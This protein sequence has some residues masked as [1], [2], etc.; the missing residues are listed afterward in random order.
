M[1]RLAET[2]GAA[3]PGVRLMGTGDVGH[4]GVPETRE[5]LQRET[6]AGG[7]VE[8]NALWESV[9]TTVHEYARHAL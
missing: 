3:P 1:C 8:R 9:S 7:V 5:V 4:A 2:C 6:Y